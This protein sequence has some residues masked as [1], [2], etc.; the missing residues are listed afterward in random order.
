MENQFKKSI[1]THIE[2]LKT[3]YKEESDKWAIE[4]SKNPKLKHPR[5]EYLT[6]YW[7]YRA[8]QCILTNISAGNYD[9]VEYYNNYLKPKTK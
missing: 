5:E 2:K 4:M 3:Y 8:Y 7:E 1:T 9:S 6:H